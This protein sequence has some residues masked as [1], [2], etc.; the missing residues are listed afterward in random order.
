MNSSSAFLRSRWSWVLLGLLALV[1]L[2]GL[3]YTNYNFAQNNPGG[4]DFLVHWVGTRAVL[5]EGQTPYSDVVAERIQRLAY[6]RP[7]QPGEHEL[8]PA[9]PLYSALIFGP[10]ALLDDFTWARAAWM[11]FLEVG[12]LALAGISLRLS[13]WQPPPL[14]LAVL[15]LFSL[16]WYHGVR[17]L[18]NGNAVVWVAVF[19]T[20]SLWALQ[21]K[22]DR[23]AGLLLALATIKPHL[24]FLPTLL[25][26]FWA[27]THRRWHFTGWF[28]GSLAVLCGLAMLW[29]PAWPLQNLAEIVRYSSYNPPTTPGGAFTQWWPS[30]GALLGWGLTG[31]VA[32]SLLWAW[33]SVW[34]APDFKRLL[35]V[36]AL[37]ITLGQ[38][39]GITTDPGNFILLFWPL[40]LVFA[41]AQARWPRLGNMGAAGVLL[42]LLVGLWVIFV[43]TIE[44]NRQQSPLMFFPLP[45]VVGLGLW[46][47][48]P[49][50]KADTISG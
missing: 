45:A 1:L 12:L 49:S 11:T 34:G 15:L 2:G 23:W 9:Y 37:T 6:G 10:F 32:A 47:T 27:S 19:L 29:V 41:C 8:R 24:V 39:S 26:L 3:T 30:F 4:N 31:L 21:H 13:Q 43:V 35:W 44:P 16:L 5:L 38:W 40:M 18:I 20:A 33:R 14:V 50:E 46:L 17:P 7:A 48:R 36:M 22:R 28:V 25:L 42:I